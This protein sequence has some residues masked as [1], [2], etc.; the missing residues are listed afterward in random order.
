M[1]LEYSR[2]IYKMC[3]DFKSLKFYYYIRY[4]GFV[5]KQFWS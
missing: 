4:Y 5:I 3:A 2:R 1:K